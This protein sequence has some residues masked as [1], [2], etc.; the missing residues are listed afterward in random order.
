[1]TKSSLESLG[2]SVYITLYNSSSR[3][4]EAGTQGRN[5]KVVTEAE[6]MEN[7]ALLLLACSTT[8]IK[9]DCYIMP[10]ILS[11]GSGVSCAEA[12]RIQSGFEIFLLAKM[13]LKTT[14]GLER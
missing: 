9:V 13:F 5:L 11:L 6:T 7:T 14:V 2:E 1:M 10:L 12:E 3:E 8:F 4:T